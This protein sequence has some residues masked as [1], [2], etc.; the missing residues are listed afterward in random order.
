MDSIWVTL[1][2]GSVIVLPAVLLLKLRDGG[3]KA[4]VRREAGRLK[5]ALEHGAVERSDW[6]ERFDLH[7]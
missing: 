4:R 7:P 2:I 3:D 6:I 5:E 1:L